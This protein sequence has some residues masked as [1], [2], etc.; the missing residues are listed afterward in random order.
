MS[1]CVN[2]YSHMYEW[3][4]CLPVSVLIVTISEFGFLLS[5][6]SCLQVDFGDNLSLIDI[7]RHISMATSLTTYGRK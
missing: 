7:W 2:V 4:M 5:G 1:E 6:Q 3:S